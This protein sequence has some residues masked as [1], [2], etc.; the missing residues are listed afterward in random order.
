MVTKQHDIANATLFAVDNVRRAGAIFVCQTNV[1]EYG[2]SVDTD[3]PIYGRTG[4]P[5]DS[6]R[7]AGGDWGGA[8]R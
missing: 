4:N 6:R 8:V 3:N 1:S 7:A 5:Y 2:M